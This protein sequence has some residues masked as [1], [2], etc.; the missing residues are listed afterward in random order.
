MKDVGGRRY[1][2]DS[3]RRDFR[4]Q[5]RAYCFVLASSPTAS[6]RI[7][8]PSHSPAA[9]T[10]RKNKRKLQARCVE[11]AVR[12]SSEKSP[13]SF[14]CAELGSATPSSQGGRSPREPQFC[15]SLLLMRTVCSRATKFGVVTWG[16][17]CF[18]GSAT[19][20]HIAQGV[21]RFVSDSRVSFTTSCTFPGIVS[22]SDG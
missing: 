19:P 6:W 3:R 4:I 18:R 20:L 5:S 11:K 8:F 14:A 15:G 17:A 9:Q 21:A 2:D 13:R 7:T 22:V 12:G 16:G 1:R 10:C